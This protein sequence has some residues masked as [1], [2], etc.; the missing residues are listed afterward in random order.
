MCLQM[1]SWRL[2]VLIIYIIYFTI[3]L[4]AYRLNNGGE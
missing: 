3:Q 4:R 2:E 1:S